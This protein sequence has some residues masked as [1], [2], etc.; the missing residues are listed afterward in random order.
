MFVFHS[1][2]KGRIVFYCLL[3]GPHI[4]PA[5]SAIFY[6]LA[7]VSTSMGSLSL[8]CGGDWVCAFLSAADGFWLFFVFWVFRRRRGSVT[9][10]GGVVRG[11][12]KVTLDRLGFCG[13]F[14]GG[15]WL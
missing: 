1:R 5:L 8:R 9:G 2:I 10:P 7:H 12:V 6:R 11:G 3:C 4:L 15:F 14:F 13:V